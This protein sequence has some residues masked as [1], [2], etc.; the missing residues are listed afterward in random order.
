MPTRPS[1]KT[2]PRPHATYLFPQDPGIGLACPVC[3]KG[4]L[5]EEHRF[6]C[7]GPDCRRAYLIRDGIPILLESESTV[8][9]P[10]DWKTVPG[11]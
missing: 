6:V 5:R 10:H 7:R 9:A 3:R 2:P 4:L 8:L 11:V 1:A